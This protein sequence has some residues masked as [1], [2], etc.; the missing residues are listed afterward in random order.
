MVAADPHGRG[1]ELAGAC[2]RSQFVEFP[3][4]RG[5]GDGDVVQDA[6]S[7]N[8]QS[9]QDDAGDGDIVRNV[10]QRGGIMAAHAGQVCRVGGPGRQ[11]R[12]DAQAEHGAQQC[13]GG[14]RREAVGEVEDADHDHGGPHQRQQQRRFSLHQPGQ[15]ERHQHRVGAHKADQRPQPAPARHGDHHGGVKDGQ[16]DDGQG[17][18]EVHEDIG[19]RTLTGRALGVG[20]VQVPD[21]VTDLD[22][23]GLHHVRVD[24]HLDRVSA[25]VRLGECEGAVIPRLR[26]ILGSALPRA[27]LGGGVLAGSALRAAFHHHALDRAGIEGHAGGGRVRAGQL[28]VRLVPGRPHHDHGCQGQERQ[29]NKHRREEPVG[30][31]ARGEGPGCRIRMVCVAVRVSGTHQQ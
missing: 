27:G 17:A 15:H 26:G 12:R 16:K 19:R 6:E 21:V 18:D 25:L 7:G 11:E 8:D 28:Q 10:R 22:A 9:A 3:H 30:P 31:F 1:K 2:L 20:E 29:R 5:L 4:R 23:V 13:R 14:S 24:H